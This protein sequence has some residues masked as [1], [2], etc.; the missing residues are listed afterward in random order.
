MDKT[1]R[2]KISNE[3]KKKGSAMKLKAYTTDYLDLIESTTEHSIQES[4]IHS[5]HVHMEHY[6]G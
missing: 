1:T 4:R 5:F 2:Q 6:L 3:K